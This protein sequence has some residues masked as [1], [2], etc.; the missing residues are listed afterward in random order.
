[1][2]LA[3]LSLHLDKIVF[4]AGGPAGCSKAVDVGS[5]K[6][7]FLPH[8]WEYIRNYKYDTLRQCVPDF[9]FPSDIFPVGLAILDTL[10][11]LAGFVAVLAIIY[12]G[13]AYMFALGNPEK[14]ASARK[15]LYNSL[16]GLGI[17]FTA[18]LF[19]AF[20]GRSLSTWWT[21][22]YWR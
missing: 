5:G 13:I 7:F 18:T 20:I 19:V 14:A 10:L 17:A 21:T 8:W 16:I 15:M 3:N 9:R 12:S 4:F 1:M 2:L 6:F 22:L 11:R